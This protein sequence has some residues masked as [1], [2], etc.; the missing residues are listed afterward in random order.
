MKSPHGWMRLL[1]RDGFIGD[2]ARGKALPWR[3]PCLPPSKR[4]GAI[5][6]S[7]APCVVIRR[8]LRHR[9]SKVL[10]ILWARYSSTEPKVGWPSSKS[11]R[12]PSMVHEFVTQRHD[13]AVA[14]FSPSWRLRMWYD[15][16]PLTGKV[17]ITTSF[18]VS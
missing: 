17:G 3:G 15:L 13:L 16:P 8:P 11:L 18:R 4:S 10:L 14:P 12:S 2:T 5:S 1:P 9:S 7:P 6:A